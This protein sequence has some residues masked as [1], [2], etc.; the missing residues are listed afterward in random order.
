[1]AE[2]PTQADVERAILEVISGLNVRANEAFNVATVQMRLQQRGFRA[3]EIN[4]A[5]ASLGEKGLIADAPT[6]G[7]RKLTDAGFAA[8]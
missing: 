4:G 3:D 8:L 5:F 6:P 1:M 7:F 2:V